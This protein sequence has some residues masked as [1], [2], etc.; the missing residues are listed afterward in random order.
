MNKPSGGGKTS[1]GKEQVMENNFKEWQREKVQ[2]AVF[3]ALADIAN[4]LDASEED[5]EFAWEWFSTHYFD[6]GMGKE[7]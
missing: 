6:E 3:N 7:N 5:M 2:S 1:A 4:E